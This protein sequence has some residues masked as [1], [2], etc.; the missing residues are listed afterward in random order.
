MPIDINPCALSVENAKI[1]NALLLQHAKACEKDPLKDRKLLKTSRQEE[2]TE[3]TAARPRSDRIYSFYPHK[4]KLKHSVIY[5]GD[6]SI[7]KIAEGCGVDKS[8]LAMFFIPHTLLGEGNFGQ[9]HKGLLYCV[10]KHT[11]VA[12]NFEIVSKKILSQ[13][14]TENTE[15]DVHREMMASNTL[16]GH[17]IHQAF[18]F[19]RKD[20]RNISFYQ[21]KYYLLLPLVKGC[22]VPVDAPSQLQHSEQSVLK[23][24]KNLLKTA[25]NLQ[26]FAGL[27]YRRMKAIHA[28]GY[29]HHDIKFDNFNLLFSDDK[30][31]D[32]TLLDF[33]LVTDNE[34][35]S[36]G[37]TAFYIDFEFYKKQRLK[38]TTSYILYKKDEY[39]YV[40]SVMFSLVAEEFLHEIQHQRCQFHEI[41]TSNKLYY[42]ITENHLALNIISYRAEWAV[43]L[44]NLLGPYDT[45]MALPDYPEGAFEALQFKIKLMLG[46]KTFKKARE[47]NLDLSTVIDSIEGAS[48]EEK[49]NPI[50]YLVLKSR[51][52]KVMND[53]K[54]LTAERQREESLA[55]LLIQ[56]FKTAVYDHLIKKYPHMMIDEPQIFEE[57]LLVIEA[58]ILDVLG[59]VTWS[60]PER[61]I[62]LKEKIR[63]KDP[64]FANFMRNNDQNLSFPPPLISLENLTLP[65]S[66]EIALPE[67]SSE[68]F[69]DSMQ[70]E[71][72]FADFSLAEQA[73]SSNISAFKEVLIFKIRQ[74]K[75]D[76]AWDE[77]ILLNEKII[78]LRSPNDLIKL[79]CLLAEKA[80]KLRL[81]ENALYYI[82]QHQEINVKLVLSVLKTLPKEDADILRR[83]IINDKTEKSY[84]SSERLFEIFSN[85]IRLFDHV[86]D[87]EREPTKK[88]LLRKECRK[89]LQYHDELLALPELARTHPGILAYY[90]E[91]IKALEYGENSLLGLSIKVFKASLQNP[92]SSLGNA[93]IDLTTHLLR[94]YQKASIHPDSPEAPILE[95][96]SIEA[97][98]AIHQIVSAPPLNHLN[99]LK[100]FN[101]KITPFIQ[102]KQSYASSALKAAAFSFAAIALMGIVPVAAMLMVGFSPIIAATTIVSVAAGIGVLVLSSQHAA[103]TG[104]IQ[105]EN[106]IYEKPFVLFS[107]QARLSQTNSK[108]NKMNTEASIARHQGRI[109]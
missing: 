57:K 86:Y 90:S 27:L 35:S 102:K 51:L 67:G 19:D 5:L 11:Q 33:G 34:D 75:V 37:G 76:I 68:S 39:A 49:T 89:I 2:K 41:I 28:Q 108:A 98:K 84:L 22:T 53:D 16:Q 78:G 97:L 48:A 105:K 24:P 81:F 74:L 9:V 70:A 65:S 93:A 99:H 44:T 96:Q 71:N 6:C 30:L 77:S 94:F 54:I 55:L 100:N 95:G 52:E 36:C 38:D 107:R 79:E 15:K 7:D 87:N 50:Y 109:I 92:D 59:D 91:Q 42:T 13:N 56:H 83:F 106:S 26:K 62:Q 88:A 69:G 64:C 12:V 10:N 40:V 18:F 60:L 20:H 66:G 58:L 61:K 25:T 85:L 8:D 45:R 82:N 1:F 72:L 104:R 17:P 23:S 31:I 47:Q 14:Q 43:V 21:N 63:L 46:D 101:K 80:E 32:L 103:K 4:I 3:R 29:V 73:Y